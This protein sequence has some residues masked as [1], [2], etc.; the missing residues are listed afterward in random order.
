MTDL[1]HAN[2][3]SVLCLVNEKEREDAELG[4]KAEPEA[5]FNYRATQNHIGRK[6]E[7]NGRICMMRIEWK[8]NNE[9]YSDLE[10][11]VSFNRAGIDTYEA[12]HSSKLHQ[13]ACRKAH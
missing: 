3:V 6:L 7:S 4:G 9:C 8:D 12:C 13:Y 2:L 1:L 11:K 5:P 10:D